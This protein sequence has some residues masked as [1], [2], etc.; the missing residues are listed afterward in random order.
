GVGAGTSDCF[1]FFGTTDCEG[2]IAN[3][4]SRGPATAQSLRMAPM[5]TAP[6]FDFAGTPYLQEA[7]VFRSSDNDN[8][9]P[10]E[11]QL[12]EGSTGTSF[13]AASLTGAAAIVRDYF[14]QGFYP[15]GARGTS[16]E[17]MPGVSGAL[18]KAALAASADFNE[19]GIA[20]QG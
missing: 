15:A 7:A 13:A 3:F 14:A 20:T 4:T 11:A 12:D 18:V 17:R 19:G 6:A 8:L 5:L 2:T 16:A 1:T 10:V 9:A